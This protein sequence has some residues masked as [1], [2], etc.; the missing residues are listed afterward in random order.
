MYATLKL[1]TIK[2]TQQGMSECEDSLVE[3]MILRILLMEKVVAWKN[4]QFQFEQRKITQ[5]R[6]KLEVLMTFPVQ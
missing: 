3:S 1:L 4:L 6:L 5:N 2:V